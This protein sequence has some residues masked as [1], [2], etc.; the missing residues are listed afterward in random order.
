MKVNRYAI[1]SLIGLIVITANCASINSAR[2]NYIM[3]GQVL[4][5]AD[6]EVYLCIGQ[7]G[8]AVV[9]QEYT[10]KKFVKTI[11]PAARKS[12]PFYKQEE[13]GTVKITEI[14]DEHYAKAV[15]TAGVA[16]ANYFVDLRQ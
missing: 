1:Y 8:G 10:V 16:K 9:G 4:E 14:V 15:I 3:S 11:N 13:T 2:H 6:N 7:S 12:E 5:V